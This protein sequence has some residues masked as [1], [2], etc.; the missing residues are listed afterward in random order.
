MASTIEE[1]LAPIPPNFPEN[2]VEEPE[3][4]TPLPIFQLLSVYLIQFAEPVTALCIYPFVNQL[5]RETGITKATTR[6]R[7]ITQGLLS[8]HSW[9]CAIR[10]LR[11]VTNNALEQESAFSPQRA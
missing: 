10:S 9:D 11:R 4:R 5:V 2:D 1:S 8:V 6:G 7:D 3:H